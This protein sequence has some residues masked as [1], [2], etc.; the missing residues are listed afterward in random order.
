M[1][2]K[3]VE[4]DP[5]DRFVLPRRKLLQALA[6]IGVTAA[7]PLAL[8]A[9]P[10]PFCY[11]D[12]T[13][14]KVELTEDTVYPLLAVW[15]LIATNPDFTPATNTGSEY[16]VFRNSVARATNLTPAC[17]DTIL[18]VYYANKPMFANV[19]LKY[20]EL[21][22]NNFAAASFYSGGHCPGTTTTITHIVRLGSS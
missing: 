22:K 14:G 13:S 5:K 7:S 18:S 10:S 4:V 8:D 12:P 6:A 1:E 16:N 19:Q 3:R 2:N 11:G 20:V 9:A 15:L 21:I 17:V